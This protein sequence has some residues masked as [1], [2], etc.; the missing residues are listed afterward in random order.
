MTAVTFTYSNGPLSLT[1]NSISTSDNLIWTG[2]NTWNN[3]AT[4]ASGVD[5]T[6]ASTVTF[7]GSVS[8]SAT[9]TTIVA[10]A[11]AWTFNNPVTF[12]GNAIFNSQVDFYNTVNF[13][14]ALTFS[15]AVTFSS[16][17]A[18]V[19]NIG[20]YGQNP[21]AKPNVTGSKG[22]NAALASLLSALNTLGLVTDTTT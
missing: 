17:V 4:F 3:N 13:H 5:F 12:N 7:E 6:G 11:A 19:G 2:T 15:S 10:G 1:I 22:G 21:Q 9:S 18:F 20:F 8:F 14:N 16:T